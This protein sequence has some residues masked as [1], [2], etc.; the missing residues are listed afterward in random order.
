[1]ESE[2][3]NEGAGRSGRDEEID[4][5]R[6]AGL[7]RVQISTRLQK[8]TTVSRPQLLSLWPWRGEKGGEA[9][10]SFFSVLLVSLILSSFDE[11]LG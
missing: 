5:D 11:A 3:E 4:G 10:S 9:M 8:A 1:M 6:G 2:T 7:L